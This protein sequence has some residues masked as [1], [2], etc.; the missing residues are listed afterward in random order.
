MTICRN[1][2]FLLPTFLLGGCV[3][4][5]QRDFDRKADLFVASVEAGM[6]VEETEVVA[7]SIFGEPQPGRTF[8]GT[9][10]GEAVVLT[11]STSN[12]IRPGHSNE[13]PLER[14]CQ[15][16]GKCSRSDL[17]GI[18]GESQDIDVYAVSRVP[19][20]YFTSFGGY[21]LAYFDDSG[22]LLGAANGI[23]MG[24]GNLYRQ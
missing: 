4:D 22:L 1:L 3:N 5:F 13:I 9:I 8:E 23:S 12:V 20:A 11:T 15:R 17:A 6:S 7:R 24:P 21:V 14:L 19:I 16:S 10:D 18:V 2:A